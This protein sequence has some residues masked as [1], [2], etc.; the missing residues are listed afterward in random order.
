MNEI[1]LFKSAIEAS[2][3]ESVFFITKSDGMFRVFAPVSSTVFQLL[4]N[5]HLGLPFNDEDGDATKR[6]NV[7]YCLVKELTSDI[8]RDIRNIP[9]VLATISNN[10]HIA[11]STIVQLFDSSCESSESSWR[12]GHNAF[13]FCAYALRSMHSA[14]SEDEL[15]SLK[16]SARLIDRAC[17]F[18]ASRWMLLSSTQL[19]TLVAKIFECL[20]YHV[21][22]YRARVYR[23]YDF[24]VSKMAGRPMLESD[25]LPRNLINEFGRALVQVKREKGW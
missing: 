25:L 12:Y 24:L 15:E 9:P 20:G 19:E 22:G 2:R 11:R 13:A 1:N 23:R 18:S 16:E 6:V 14:L 10:Q 7:K 8:T 21:S 3:S 4:D 17:G 5:E